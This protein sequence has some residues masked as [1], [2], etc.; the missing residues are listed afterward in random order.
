MSALIRILG[1]HLTAIDILPDPPREP[2]LVD[3]A[4]ALHAIERQLWPIQSAL[5]AAYDAEEECAQVVRRHLPVLRE[6]YAKLGR[7]LQE[8]E[9]TD[10]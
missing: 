9:G 7:L 6:L 3:F 1:P 8:M 10:G 2:T 5:G 4:E